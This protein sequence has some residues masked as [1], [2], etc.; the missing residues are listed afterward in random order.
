MAEEIKSKHNYPVLTR[1]N[2][3][4]GMFA[5]HSPQSGSLDNH[6]LA[7]NFGLAASVFNL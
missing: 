3:R 4:F 7:L 5:F 2:F 6:T 1:H